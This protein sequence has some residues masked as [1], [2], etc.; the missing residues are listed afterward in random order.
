M[1][2]RAKPTSWLLLVMWCRVASD[3]DSTAQQMT[4]L[5]ID[6]YCLICGATSELAGRN[7]CNVLNMPKSDRSFSLC[8]RSDT[9]AYGPNSD[10][11]SGIADT[12][13]VSN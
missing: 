13:A 8:Y 7:A 12:A 1:G 3:T 6:A 11:A 4:G 5:A 2:H 9:D 10:N